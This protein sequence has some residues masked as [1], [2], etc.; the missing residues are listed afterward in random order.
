[1]T[2]W[3][4]ESPRCVVNGRALAGNFKT[5]G[6]KNK[7]EKCVVLQSACVCFQSICYE[8]R[9]LFVAFPDV[10]FYF[11]VHLDHGPVSLAASPNSDQKS[12][13]FFKL[14]IPSALLAYFQFT[15]RSSY[16]PREESADEAV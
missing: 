12:N 10:P 4:S 8:M 1:M 11:G 15:S 9:V 13:S 5:S 3:R 2:K 7:S 14:C 6:H 16:P